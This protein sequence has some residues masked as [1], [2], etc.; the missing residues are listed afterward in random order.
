MMT[1]IK[2]IS[3]QA[4]RQKDLKQA[5]IVDVRT[6]MEFAEKRLALPTTLAR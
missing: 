5:L 4:L 1:T 2:S 3:A 6:P